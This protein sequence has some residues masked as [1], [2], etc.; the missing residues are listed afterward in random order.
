MHRSRLPLAASSVVMAAVLGLAACASSGPAM[1]LQTLMPA[2][3]AARDAAASGR[4][5][6]PIVLDAIRLPAQVDQPQWLVRLPD[7]SVVALEQE[8]WA[9]PLRDEFRQAL[10]EELIV[11]DGVVEARA[12]VAGAPQ[13]LRLSVDVRRFDSIPGLEARIEGSWTLLSGAPGTPPWR[14]EW[15]VRETAGPAIPEL[16]AAHR[17]AVVR[18]A[19][20]IGD[21]LVALG[22]GGPL[23]CPRSDPR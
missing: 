1:H 9:S 11:H 3:L 5:P 4:A 2:A 8:R 20:Q 18:L 10:L 23:D 22:R 12:S 7:G 13:P 15:L 16:A 14:C 21:S 19:D 6:I 17:R